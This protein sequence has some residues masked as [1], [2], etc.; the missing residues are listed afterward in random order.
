MSTLTPVQGQ[1]LPAFSLPATVRTAEAFTETIFTNEGM[2]GQNWVLFVYPRDNT[3][4]CTVE[5][6]GFAALHDQFV[7]AKIA[8]LGLSRDPL[9]THTKFIEKQNL[10]Y[11]LLSD[12][13]GELLT[14]W[15]LLTAGSMYGKPVTRVARTTYLIDKSGV[16]AKVWEKVAPPGHATAVLEAARQLT[17]G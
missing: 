15:G 14:R 4:G 8:V 13:D 5:A 10:P 1:P 6:A 2:L 11:P 16:V 12:A 3:P 9:K 7:E 17:K